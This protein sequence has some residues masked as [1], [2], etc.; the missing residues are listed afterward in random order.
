MKKQL[1]DDSVDILRCILWQYNDAENLQS[2][3]KQKQEWYD[4]SYRD[5]WD[6]WIVNV[7]TLETLN[8]FGCSV[9]SIILGI[10]FTVTIP[11]STTPSWG[12]DPY[13]K[14]FFNGNFGN[15]SQGE[16]GATLKQK[17]LILK[18]RYYQLIGRGTVPESNRFM[19]D[20]F[21]NDGTVFV[22]DL[23]DMTYAVYVFDFMP[24]SQTLFV[25]QQYDLLPRP[26]G[27]GILLTIANR[28]PWGFDPYDTNFFNGNF[29]GQP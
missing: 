20:V 23:Y 16:Q 8:D 11:A 9:W 22:Q 15:A 5:F 12:F 26:A 4:E 7:F 24:D 6:D 21:Q 28:I 10:N 17:R 29:I 19:K 3:I 1:F 14:N 13:N 27:V 25:L 18:L 2:L